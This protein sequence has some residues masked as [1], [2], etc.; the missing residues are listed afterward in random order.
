MEGKRFIMREANNLA[1]LTPVENIKTMYE[2]AKIYGR[3]FD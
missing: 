2:A 1:P 3:Y